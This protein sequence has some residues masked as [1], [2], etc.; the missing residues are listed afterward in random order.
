MSTLD[1]RVIP[2]HERLSILANYGIATGLRV[3]SLRI[4]G[5]SPIMDNQMKKKM[6]WTLARWLKGMIIIMDPIRYNLGLLGLN[7]APWL[8]WGAHVG[9]V[10]LY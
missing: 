10:Y 6:N 7:K 4:R 5:L 2:D 9:R 3:E 8:V 1:H